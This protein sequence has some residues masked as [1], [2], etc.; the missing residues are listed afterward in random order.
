MNFIVSS[1][2]ACLHSRFYTPRWVASDSACVGQRRKP[3]N[4]IAETCNKQ[5]LLWYINFPIHAFSIIM[6]LKNRWFVIIYLHVKVILCMKCFFLS[7]FI[8]IQIDML[9]IGYLNH[10]LTL[11]VLYTHWSE[12]FKY[13]VKHCAVAICVICKQF[14]KISFWILCWYIFRWNAVPYISYIRQVLIIYHTT[15]HMKYERYIAM[16]QML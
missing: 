10:Y 13:T 2:H 16:P 11:A 6:A 14:W 5:L 15:H 12:S 9:C 7:I 4:S 8:N 3:S 1:T